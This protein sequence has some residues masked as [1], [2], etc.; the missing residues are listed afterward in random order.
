MPTPSAAVEDVELLDGHV[1]CLG[2][3]VAKCEGG[4]VLGPGL[5]EFDV[6]AARCAGHDVVDDVGVGDEGA[7]GAD[8]VGVVVD[9]HDGDVEPDALWRFVLEV[10]HADRGVDDQAVDDDPVGIG[11]ACAS[12]RRWRWGRVWPWSLRVEPAG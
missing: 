2:Q 7:G 3:F 6:L 10:V 12:G 4:D 5:D 8:P 11:A 9:G 1:D